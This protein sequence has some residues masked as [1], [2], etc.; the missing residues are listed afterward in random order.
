V[1]WQ[2]RKFS[3][4]Q[5]QG[6]VK[7]GEKAGHYSFEYPGKVKV[8]IPPEAIVY[9]IQETTSDNEF[10]LIDPRGKKH[11]FLRTDG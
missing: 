8:E 10:A 4:G 7:Q 9:Q 3:A 1:V 5:K 2:F 11:D 6:E